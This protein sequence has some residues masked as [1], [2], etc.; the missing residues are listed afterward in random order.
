MQTLVAPQR[1]S[2][3]TRCFCSLLAGNDDNPF[4]SQP[5]VGSASVERVMLQWVSLCCLD[6]SCKPRLVGHMGFDSSGLISIHKHQVLFS[7]SC[8]T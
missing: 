3:Q 1:F 4:S 6:R 5:L 8:A 2:A 7:R